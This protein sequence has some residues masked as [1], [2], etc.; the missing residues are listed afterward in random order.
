MPVPSALLVAN[1]LCPQRQDAEGALELFRTFV[2]GETDV[3]NDVVKVKIIDECSGAGG[4]HAL[5]STTAN[6][7]RFWL[8][9]HA[10][11]FEQE[12]TES[13]IAVGIGRQTQTLVSA[14]AGWCVMYP[15]DTEPFAS[16]VETQALAWFETDEEA[17]RFIAA[18]EDD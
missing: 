6:D 13:G 3:V 18:V 12:G 14:E 8:G 5:S 1:D 4:M 9:A 17:A 7:K 2:D 11:Y 15:D 16:D 10:C